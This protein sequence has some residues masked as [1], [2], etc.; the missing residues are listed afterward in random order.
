MLF[1]IQLPQLV[2]KNLSDSEPAPHIFSAGFTSPNVQGMRETA[3]AELRKWPCDLFIFVLETLSRTLGGKSFSEAVTPLT[4][5]GT[6]TMWALA[7]KTTGTWIWKGQY[8]CTQPLAFS[9][10]V[11]LA[12]S[13]VKILRCTINWV[14]RM[15]LFY[16]FTVIGSEHHNPFNKFEFIF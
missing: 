1:C 6:S 4:T 16:C 3:R 8:Y 7:R 14:G 9:K 10:V 12:S 13:S 15:V 11:F 5:L 2:N